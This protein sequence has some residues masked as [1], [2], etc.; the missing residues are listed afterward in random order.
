M[1]ALYGYT[2]GICRERK[3]C[4]NLAQRVAVMMSFTTLAAVGLRTNRVHKFMTI[5]K[6]K[7]VWCGH[8][9]ELC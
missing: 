3:A 7:W 6:E 2:M 1:I 4:F 5:Q 8:W 9:E